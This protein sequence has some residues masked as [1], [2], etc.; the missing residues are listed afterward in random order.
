MLITISPEPRPPS[1]ESP[2]EVKSSKLRRLGIILIVLIV[3]FVGL[4]ALLPS[5]KPPAEEKLLKTF[6]SN[7]STYE[8]LRDM[9]QTDG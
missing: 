5:N 6:Y 4:W 7:R 9:L 1:S 3:V 8:H 2:T